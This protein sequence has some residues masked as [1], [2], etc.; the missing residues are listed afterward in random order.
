MNAAFC[1]RCG[2]FLRS[3]YRHHFTTCGCG[4]LSLDGGDDYHRTS[5]DPSYN[6][7]H[8][9]VHDAAAYWGTIHDLAWI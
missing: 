5:W 2:D 7:V 4:A 3:R 8:H 6:G 1:G 9:F